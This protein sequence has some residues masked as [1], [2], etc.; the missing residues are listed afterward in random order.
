MCKVTTGRTTYQRRCAK[1]GKVFTFENLAKMVLLVI[2]IILI[3]IRIVLLAVVPQVHR[4]KRDE[5]P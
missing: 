3:A 5:Y 2:S 4:H 1:G